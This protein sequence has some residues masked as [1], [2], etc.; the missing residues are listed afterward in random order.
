MERLWLKLTIDGGSEKVIVN[1]ELLDLKGYVNNLMLNLYYLACV[2]RRLSRVF[3]LLRKLKSL[4]A[5][6]YLLGMYFKYFGKQ[7]AT[8]V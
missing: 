3:Y 8:T 2:G 4:I 6:S 5:P 7:P 1:L